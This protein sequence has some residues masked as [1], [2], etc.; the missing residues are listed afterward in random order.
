MSESSNNQNDI[1][2]FICGEDCTQSS[3]IEHFHECQNSNDVVKN[4]PEN[5]YTIITKLS[6]K[7]N[8]DEDI[9][10]YN[11]S[12]KKHF[13]ICNRKSTMATSNNE[14][15]ADSN[16]VEMIYQEMKKK[17]E[18]LN[19]KKCI[20]YTSNAKYVNKCYHRSKEIAIEDIS[21]LSNL[22]V[23]VIKNN[24]KEKSV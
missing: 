15:F 19:R 3:F 10:A 8:I 22:N 5:F 23:K 12:A 17:V 13:G 20:D 14:S 16:E 24:V 11:Y 21:T 7:E 9:E 1:F 6:L 2:C 4:Y 18:K